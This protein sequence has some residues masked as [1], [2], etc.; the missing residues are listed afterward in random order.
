MSPFEAETFSI[1]CPKQRKSDQYMKIALDWFSVIKKNLAL[2][3]NIL[4]GTFRRV[5]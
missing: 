2:N 1:Y 5:G 3:R 4:L